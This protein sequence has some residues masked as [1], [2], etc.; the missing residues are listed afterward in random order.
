M[1]APR[2]PVAAVL[3]R[4]TIASGVDGQSSTETHTSCFR[5]TAAKTSPDTTPNIV[6][7]GI[8]GVRVSIDEDRGQLGKTLIM[9]C[10]LLLVQCFNGLASETHLGDQETLSK[11]GVKDDA[12][13]TDTHIVTFNRCVV[14]LAASIGSLRSW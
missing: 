8:S 5:R 14:N 11:Y 1:M 4:T 7:L 9:D 3:E 6:V 13:S 2:L 10:T 12:K